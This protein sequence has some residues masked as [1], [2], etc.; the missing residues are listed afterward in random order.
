MLRRRWRVARR[1][2][3]GRYYVMGERYWTRWG[4]VNRMRFL[5]QSVHVLQGLVGGGTFIAMKGDDEFFRQ[6]AG[7]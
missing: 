4:A 1:L 2:E 3:G 6:F 5:N 7:D